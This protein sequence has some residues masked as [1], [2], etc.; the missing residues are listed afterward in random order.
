M[1]KPGEFSQPSEPAQPSESPRKPGNLPSP[2]LV[3]F[4][5]GFMTGVTAIRNLTL[6]VVIQIQYICAFIFLSYLLS[7]IHDTGG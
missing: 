5:Q 1:I 7:Q 6:W 3:M 2:A 4:H